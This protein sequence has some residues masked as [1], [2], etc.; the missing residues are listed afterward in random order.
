MIVAVYRRPEL[1]LEE[2]ESYWRDTHGPLAAIY[3]RVLGM[4]RYVQSYGIDAPEIQAFAR[5]RG[6]VEPPEALAEV[7]WESRDAM[8]AAFDTP[9]GREASRI[10]AEDEAKFC[11]MTRM[12]AFLSYENVVFSDF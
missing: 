2:F 5:S 8:E 6:W 3:G 1:T 7:W 10:L 12:S 4:K 11:D 9:E